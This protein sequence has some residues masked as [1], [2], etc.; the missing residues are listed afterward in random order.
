MY[1][2]TQDIVRK[3]VSARY[4]TKHRLNLFSLNGNGHENSPVED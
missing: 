3:I 1:P 2:T 4:S